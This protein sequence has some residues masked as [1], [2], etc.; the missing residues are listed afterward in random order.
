MRPSRLL[1]IPLIP[2]GVLGFLWALGIVLRAHELHQQGLLRE[3]LAARW[4]REFGPDSPL[5]LCQHGFH[6]VRVARDEQGVEAV[7][8]RCGQRA[9][10]FSYGRVRPSRRSG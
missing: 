4:E 8:E 2:A 5:W 9:W 3:R 1:L 10:A 7:C 6:K